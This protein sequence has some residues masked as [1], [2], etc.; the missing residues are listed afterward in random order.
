MPVPRINF[1]AGAFPAGVGAAGIM[2]P[3]TPPAELPPMPD[4]VPAYD[5][6]KRDFVL[7]ANGRHQTVH[8]Y[9]QQVQL[10]LGVKRGQ[11]A[12]DQD[13]GHLLDM[14]KTQGGAALVKRLV[15]NQVDRS[16][17]QLISEGKIRTTSRV[18]TVSTTSIVVVYQ[19]MNLGSNKP[20]TYQYTY[21][22]TRSTNA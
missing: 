17:S 16:V 12:S 5:M 14:A 15:E 4:G 10:A 9:D 6:A 8:P 13:Q 7:D 11:F 1:G 21:G 18:V 3:T 22:G 20:E 2:P 19:Y